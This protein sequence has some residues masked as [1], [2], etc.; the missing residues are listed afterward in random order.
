MAQG[1]VVMAGNREQTLAAFGV[2]RSPMFHIQ[3]SIDQ[4][5]DQMKRIVEERKSITE[6]GYDSRRYVE[7]VH[8]YV[9]NAQKYVDAW[10]SAGNI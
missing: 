10:K 2:E 5:Y 3:P 7:D 6:W 1:K 4:I 8:H 9:K